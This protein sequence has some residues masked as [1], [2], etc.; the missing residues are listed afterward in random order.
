MN[1][2][3]AENG[4]ALAMAEKQQALNSC[5]YS[6]HPLVQHPLLQSSRA[7]LFSYVVSDLVQQSGDAPWRRRRPVVPSALRRLNSEF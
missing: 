4:I 7:L 2:T 6:C 1:D 3:K 5:C